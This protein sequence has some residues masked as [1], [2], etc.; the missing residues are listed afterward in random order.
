VTSIS[1]EHFGF[2]ATREEVRIF[3]L[4][5]V[6]GMA[7][8][9]I[10]YG[11]IVTQLTAPD[12][13]GA[14]A[15][16]I[17][18]CKTL[19]DYVKDVAYVGAIIGRYA[20]RIAKGQFIVNGRT[21]RVTTNAPPNSLHGGNVGFNKVV[22]GVT[23]FEVTAHGPRLT[24]AHT[25]LDG[26]QGFPGTLS[27]TAVYTLSNS[28]E[29]RLELTATTTQATVVNLTQHSYFNL[30]GY[31]D[32]LS[33]VV[34]IEADC[35]TPVDGTL[36]PSGELEPVAGSPF[37]FR[38][39]T[40][41]GARIGANHE[42]LKNG[43]GYDHNWVI[44]RERSGLIRLASAYEL[45]TGRLLEVYSTEPGLQFYS[46]NSL[47]GTL[48]GKSGWVYKTR[49]GFCMEPQHFPDSPSKS[50]F[51]STLL[52]PGETYRSTIMYR[53]SVPS[54]DCP[55][56]NEPAATI[57]SEGATSTP[58]RSPPNAHGERA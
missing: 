24:L 43:N 18:G 51:P 33:H 19:A 32:I 25:S 34:Q 45:E 13:H 50:H 16:I 2:T 20:N 23:R 28:N 36:I 21:Y 52:N 47:D 41:I 31:G 38:I 5:N 42:Q 4:R 39:P 54:H 55:E 56:S 29:L 26:D 6:Q 58:S 8:R 7:A 48:T 30:R 11:G 3:T 14:Y 1:H 15:D 12:R 44:N 46:G 22:W 40:P 35:F 49:N 57:V 9:I 53:F 17:L 37:D 10:T 27:V